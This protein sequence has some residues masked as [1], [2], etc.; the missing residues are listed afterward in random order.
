MMRNGWRFGVMAVAAAAASCGGGGDSITTTTPQPPANRAPSAN[1]AF[2]CA[3][4]AC[5][6]TSTSTDQD[7]GDAIV[8]QSWTFGDASAAASTNNPPHAFAT[9]GAYSV[10]LTVVDRS[11]ATNSISRQVFVT[12]PPVPAAPRAGFT[13]SCQSLDCSFTD[14]STYEAGSVFQSRRWDF[15][16]GTAIVTTSPAAHRYGATALTTYSVKLAVTDAAGKTSSSVQTIVAAP[17]ASTL[18]CTGGSCVLNLTTASRVTATIVSRECS[19]RNN[20]V[21]ITAPITETA[22]ADGCYDPVGVAVPVNGGAVFAANTTLQVEVRSGTFAASTLVFAPSIRVS[23]TFA[24]GW[25]LTFDDGFGGPGEPDF[26]DL[27]ILI[28]AAP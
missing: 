8:S 20:Q 25:T 26:N 4:L 1:F 15:G 21:V 14:T 23:G 7:V 2:S 24:I 5:T 13:A 9:A 19:A 28:K 12:A 16:D 11:G 6:F 27:V 22:F 3:D 17:P 18:N 10:A